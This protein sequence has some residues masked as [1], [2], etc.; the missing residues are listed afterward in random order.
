MPICL[1]C[2]AQIICITHNIYMHAY[3][4]RIMEGCCRAC[5]D[6]GRMDTCRCVYNSKKEALED[7][8]SGVAASMHAIH[9][10]RHG[11]ICPQAS[12]CLLLQLQRQAGRG[13]SKKGN[14]APRGVRGW[15]KETVVPAAVCK[16]WHE[17]SIVVHRSHAFHVHAGAARPADLLLQS[18]ETACMH[19]WLMQW[20][21][22]G[23]ITSHACMNADDD[24]DDDDDDDAVASRQAGRPAVGVRGRP[25]FASLAH[26]SLHSSTPHR[27]DAIIHCRLRAA[28]QPPAHA[29]PRRSPLDRARPAPCCCCRCRALWSAAA[30]CRYGTG[31]E[32][33]HMLPRHAPKRQRAR[34]TCAVG[35]CC[36]DLLACLVLWC[37]AS[38]LPRPFLGRPGARRRRRWL[39][40]G[41]MRLVRGLCLLERSYLSWTFGRI[42]QHIY[43][44]R[45]S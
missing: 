2:P 17:Y 40:V 44:T 10:I 24:D 13:G 20:W 26:C 6:D 27:D 7:D 31:R 35:H 38:A 21:M 3:I 4:Q 8:S 1:P 34:A 39:V 28:L 41:Q 11:M 5:M 25:M 19:A 18:W 32:P 29:R 9:G 14:P 43:S 42:K 12:C 36:C 15:C 16:A 22:D 30:V 45:S 23:S 33:M 37:A